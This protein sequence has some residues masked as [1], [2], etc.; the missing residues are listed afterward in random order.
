M[1]QQTNKQLIN[2]LNKL[3]NKIIDQ[4]PTGVLRQLVVELVDV[5]EQLARIERGICLY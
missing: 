3:T 5:E 2:Q 1:K 4:T